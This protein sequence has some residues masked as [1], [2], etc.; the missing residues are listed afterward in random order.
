MIRLFYI[1]SFITSGPN[2]AV[3]RNRLEGKVKIRGNLVFVNIET[4]F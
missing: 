2:I 4:I 1:H 3:A